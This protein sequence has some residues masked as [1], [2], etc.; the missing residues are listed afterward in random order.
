M[1]RHAFPMIR[2]ARDRHA[3]QRVTRAH[4]VVDQRLA[5]ELVVVLAHVERALFEIEDRRGAVECAQPEERVA[6]LVRVQ[7]DEARRYCFPASVDHRT[8]VEGLPRDRSDDAV[9]DADVAHR[10]QSRFRIENAPTRD[11]Q[12]VRF[13]KRGCWR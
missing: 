12:V 9:A 10:V 3:N 4:A 6:M 2:I 7:V 11:H 8:A 5:G 13:R 1:N